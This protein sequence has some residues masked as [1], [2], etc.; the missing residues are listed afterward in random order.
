MLGRWDPFAELSRIQDGFARVAGARRQSPPS[1]TPPSFTPAVNIYEAKDAILVKVELPGVKVED[2]T[3]GVENHVLTVSGERVIEKSEREASP[4]GE[5][6]QKTE[7]DG[8]GWHRVE[9]TYGAFSRSFALPNTI[10]SGNIEATMDAGILTL[11][12]P[13]RMDA[14]PRKIRINAKPAEKNGAVEA[15]A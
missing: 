15:R 5:R 7:E 8:E 11:R 12:V 1:S 6:S 2:V 4:K 9:S 13:K 14:Q 3:I 10:D